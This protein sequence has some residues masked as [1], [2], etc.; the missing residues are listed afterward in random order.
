METGPGAG[1][2]EL[3]LLLVW[4]WSRGLALEPMAGPRSEG[5]SCS[6]GLG[7]GSGAG[8]WELV[9][10][11]WS[12]PGAWDWAVVLVPEAAPGAP[13]WEL[14]LASLPGPGVEGRGLFPEP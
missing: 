8:V 13:C 14:V 6:R 10:E 7:A 1:G 2:W 5:W 9:L 12:G 3:V 4:S 11:P